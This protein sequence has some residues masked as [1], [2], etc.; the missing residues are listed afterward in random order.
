MKRN[1]EKIAEEAKFRKN[2]EQKAR[3]EKNA[4]REQEQQNMGRGEDAMA[5]KSFAQGVVNFEGKS[6]REIQRAVDQDNMYRCV[7]PYKKIGGRL[8]VT[9]G[10]TKNKTLLGS[11]TQM[12]PIQ[13]DSRGK[14]VG[15]LRNGQ[16]C[17]NYCYNEENEEEE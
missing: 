4:K 16:E 13:K 8:I 1:N 10:E 12:G 17:R 11:C 14:Y 15:Y 7:K 3:A 6:L 2:A 5:H 9:P